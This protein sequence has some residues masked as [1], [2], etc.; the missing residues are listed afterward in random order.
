MLASSSLRSVMVL[1]WARLEPGLYFRG[2]ECGSPRPAPLLSW[3]GFEKVVPPLSPK[4]LGKLQ[5][6]LCPPGGAERPIQEE[7]VLSLF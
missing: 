7:K 1:L 3:E 4:K 6:S 5:F 2:P